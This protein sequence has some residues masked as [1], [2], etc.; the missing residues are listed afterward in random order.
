MAKITKDNTKE[1]NQLGKDVVEIKT[2][3]KYIKTD[4]N[5]IKECF[6]NTVKNDDAHKEIVSHNK[7]MWDERNRII[8]WLFGAGIVGGTTGAL[9]K[10]FVSGIFA[11]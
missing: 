9:I 11:K 7:T 10:Q 4:I 2:D 1:I 6:N 5:E 3:I 8:G